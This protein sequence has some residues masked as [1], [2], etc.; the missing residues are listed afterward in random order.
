MYLQGKPSLSW[1][2][3]AAGMALALLP[4]ALVMGALLGE[5]ETFSAVVAGGCFV[6]CIG[7]AAMRWHAVRKRFK[8]DAMEAMAAMRQDPFAL[9]RGSRRTSILW[10]LATSL[11]AIVGTLAWALWNKLQ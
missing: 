6:F 5:G 1:W 2:R 8:G 7:Y 11:M 10:L 3:F 9:M 4:I